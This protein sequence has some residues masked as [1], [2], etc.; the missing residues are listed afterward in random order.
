MSTFPN[1]RE[2]D[3]Y[4]MSQTF[5]TDFTDIWGGFKDYKIVSLSFLMFNIYL[6]YDYRTLIFGLSKSLVL[7]ENRARLHAL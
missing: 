4:L 1:T 6:T 5:F 7:N 2:K 3:R